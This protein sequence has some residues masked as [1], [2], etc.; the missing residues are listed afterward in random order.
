MLERSA[1][2]TRPPP[3][4]EDAPEDAP[5]P[6]SAPTFRLQ[7]QAVPTVYQPNVAYTR[8]TVFFK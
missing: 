4:A 8:T 7:N 3:P 1:A 6:P 2:L 5:A